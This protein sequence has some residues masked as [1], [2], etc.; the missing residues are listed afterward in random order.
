MTSI[1]YSP[2]TKK[3]NTELE[4]TISVE[5]IIE[6]YE[7]MGIDVKNNFKALEEICI[8]RCKQTGY[9]FY[10]PNSIFEDGTFYQI[11][12]NHLLRME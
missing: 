8:I 12:Q 4:E 5:R 1:I 9:R 7:E 10:F 3:P 6:A 11:L 2:L